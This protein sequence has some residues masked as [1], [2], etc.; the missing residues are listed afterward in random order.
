MLEVSLSC[1]M[2][3]AMWRGHCEKAM[4]SIAGTPLTPN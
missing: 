3:P 4:V 2:V 1:D